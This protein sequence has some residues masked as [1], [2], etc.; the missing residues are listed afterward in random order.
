[1]Y[2]KPLALIIED[3]EDQSLVFTT[4]LEQAGYETEAIMDGSVAQKRLGEVEPS[5]IV[6]DLHVPGVNGKTLLSQ[7]RHDERLINVPV[8]LATADAW[9]AETLRSQATL[10]L[11]KPI[12]FSQLSTLASRFN[13]Y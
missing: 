12:S 7:I 6:L 11:L 3:H 13:L 4:A 5:M 1:M 2:K 8:I 9:Q 10:V